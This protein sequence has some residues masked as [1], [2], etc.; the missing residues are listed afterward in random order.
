MFG[1]S[2]YWEPGVYRFH[3]TL[4]SHQSARRPSKQ[5]LRMFI[6][7]EFDVICCFQAWSREGDAAKKLELWEDAAYAYYQAYRILPSDMRLAREFQAAIAK[8]REEHNA[9]QKQSKA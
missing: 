2:D 8:G 7:A 9:K 3:I 5:I 6:L 1:D 4:E